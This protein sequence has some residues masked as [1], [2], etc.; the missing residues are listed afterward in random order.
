[1]LIEVLAFLFLGIFSGIL[2]GLIPGVHVNLIGALL[3]FLSQNKLGFLDPIYLVV[4]IVSMSITHTFFDFIPSI[5]LGVPEDGTELSVLPG[6]EMLKKGFGYEAIKLSAYGGLLSLFILFVLIFPS[7][8]LLPKVYFFFQKSNLIAYFLILISLILIFSD[9]KKIS[10]FFV[11]VITGILGLIVLNLEFNEPLLP[12]LSG[13]FGASML[14]LSI[15]MKTKIPKQKILDRKIIGKKLFKPILGTSI[16]SPLLSMF[17][18]IGSGQIAV[19]GSLITKLD[20]RGFLVLLGATNTLV[21]GLS[22]VFF[23]SISRSRTGSAAAIQSLL[24]SLNFKIL[25]FILVIALLSGIFSF[26]LVLKI[27]KF[28]SKKIHFIN[29]S[30]LSKLTLIF[31]FIVVFLISGFLGSLV[32]LVST[33]TGIFCIGLSVKRTQMMGSLLLPTIILYLF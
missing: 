9:K 5:F 24:E 12:L 21:M 20:N 14:I 19:L 25:I 6:H 33:I 22:F 10:S 8:F 2:T 32:F 4:F 26:L 3:V 18:G 31:V 13:L 1:M 29:Y 17:P 23:Y 28:F 7:V 11:F 16:A 27:G 15:K 30:F